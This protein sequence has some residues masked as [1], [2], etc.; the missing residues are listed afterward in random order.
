MTDSGKT[1]TPSSPS[2]TTT[3]D[4]PNGNA[5]LLSVRRGEPGAEWLVSDGATTRFGYG[6]TIED[7]ISDYLDALRELA[8]IKGPC[9]PPIAAEVEYARRVFR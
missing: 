9:G 3:A 4:A 8:D 7:A 2:V 5:L 6:A 1:Y